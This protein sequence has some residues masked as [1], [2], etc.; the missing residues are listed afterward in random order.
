MKQRAMS[1]LAAAT[2]VVSV[3]GASVTG[4]QNLDVGMS[5]PVGDSLK[6]DPGLDEPGATNPG[7]N[8]V[9]VN[10]QGR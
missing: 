5:I 1:L 7:N 2:I 6:Q 9:P 10:P 8:I 3:A 4:C